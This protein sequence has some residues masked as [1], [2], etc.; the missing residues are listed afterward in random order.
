MNVETYLEDIRG[1]ILSSQ[2]RG[3]LARDLLMKISSQWNKF[4]GHIDSFYGELVQVSKFCP[5]TAFLLIGRSSNAIWS[6]MRPFRTQISLL[7]NMKTLDNKAAFIWGVLQ[8][9]RV[10][11]EFIK[12][13]FQGHP[14]FVKEMS[15]FVL[16]ERVDPSEISSLDSTIS[17]LRTIVHDVQKSNKHL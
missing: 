17:R 4:V 8:C 11:D 15:L 12:L 7:G 1:T 3:G 9:H 6:A 5:D 2:N 13:D 10:M 14:G 16:T